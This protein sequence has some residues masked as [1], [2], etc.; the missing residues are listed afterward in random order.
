MRTCPRLPPFSCSPPPVLSLTPLVPL[1]RT[2]K[3]GTLFLVYL[4]QLSKLR[5]NLG[6]WISKRL[7]MHATLVVLTMLQFTATYVPLVGRALGSG[8]CVGRTKEG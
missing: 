1:R 2:R 6:P 8:G 4:H 5:A 3:N 7:P